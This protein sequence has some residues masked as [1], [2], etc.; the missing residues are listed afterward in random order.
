MRLSFLFFI[1]FL[2][3]LSISS[4]ITPQKNIN[5][6]SV[7]DMI[8]IPGGW[9]YIGSDEG[10]PNEAPQH[11][12]M[13]RDFKI[14]AYEISAT[15]FAA[16]LNDKGNPDDRYFTC[17]EYAVVSCLNGEGKDANLVLGESISSYEPRPGSS[18]SPANNVSWYGAE[19]FCSWKEKRLPTEAEWEKASRGYDRRLYPW[20]N[21]VPDEF[22]ARY[23]EK[24]KEKGID[25]LMPVN[26]LPA[27]R[28]FY[29]IHNM[30]GNILE[31]I[32]DWYRRNYC[33]FCDP[34]ELHY[35]A[36][37]AEILGQNYVPVPTRKKDPNLPPRE[38]AAG[39][40]IGA[41][42]ILRG[43]SWHDKDISRL[44]SSYRFWLDPVE[45][46][47]YTGFRCAS[48]MVE[49]RRSDKSE[50]VVEKVEEVFLPGQN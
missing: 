8:L 7:D 47:A 9:F 48:D 20:G 37:A 22:K 13:V 25:V 23:R 4:C 43:G 45:R 33:D 41:F 18:H 35:A 15:E 49:E 24:W 38:N 21:Q 50:E 2:L 10:E 34:G 32:N 39:P 46:Y 1:T 6:L 42:K 36:A 16:F 30:S 19:A 5:H 44:R 40:P 17:N 26:S 3:S 27:G 12:V 31:W 29:G 14:D 11:E 28:S